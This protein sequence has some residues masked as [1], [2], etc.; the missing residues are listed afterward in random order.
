MGTNK[1]SHSVNYN[2][3][4]KSNDQRKKNEIEEGKKKSQK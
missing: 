2:L 1:G 3:I 4:G